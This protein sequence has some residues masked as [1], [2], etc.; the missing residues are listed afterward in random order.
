MLRVNSAIGMGAP[1]PPSLLRLWISTLSDWFSFGAVTV[2][3]MTDGLVETRM[4]GVNP[5][6]DHQGGES[7]NCQV[8]LRLLRS[9]RTEERAV[10]ELMELGVPTADFSVT[11]K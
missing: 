3:P 11:L 8:A 2:P 6:S 7:V 4:F 10:A 9:W 1:T 5:L